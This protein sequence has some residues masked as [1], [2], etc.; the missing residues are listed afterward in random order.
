MN[1]TNEDFRSREVSNEL[2]QLDTQAMD[3][4]AADLDDPNAPS[5]IA[6]SEKV[7]AR[8]P[9]LEFTPKPDRP[10][11]VKAHNA[12]LTDFGK[13]TL[14]DRYL[15]PDESFQ[16]MFGRVAQAYGDDTAHAQRL[17]DYMSQLWFCLLYTSP[18]PRDGLLSR[19]P[20]S[21]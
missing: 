16:D 2:N 7:V 4:L 11:Q 20:S 1:E 17:Y 12:L 9:E 14:L 6:M 13:R 10:K 8:E 19:M 5:G 18:S 3:V 21:A 15:L